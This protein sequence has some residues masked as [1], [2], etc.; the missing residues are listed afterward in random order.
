MDINPKI[1]LMPGIRKEKLYNV[2]TWVFWK[3]IKFA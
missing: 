2:A 1:Q 3:S